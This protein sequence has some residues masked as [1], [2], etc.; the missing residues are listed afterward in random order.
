MVN[1]YY[2][3]SMLVRKIG[4]T[5]KLL[6]RPVCSV[7]IKLCKVSVLILWSYAIPNDMEKGLSSSDEQPFNAAEVTSR[8]P[9]PGGLIENRHLIDAPNR[10]SISRV[11]CR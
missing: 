10:T 11:N 8:Y 9:T 1:R 2:A 3:H 6:I 7:L 5:S 4:N